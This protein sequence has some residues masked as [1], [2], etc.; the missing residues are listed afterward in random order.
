MQLSAF[1]YTDKDLE[2]LLASLYNGEIDPL[3][4]PEDLYL[5]VAKFVMGGVEKGLS[6]P[7]VEFGEVDQKLM[8]ALSENIHLFSAAKTFNFTLEASDSMFDKNGKLLPFEDFKIKATQV[9]E[10]YH[11]EIEHGTIKGGWLEAEYNTALSQAGHVKKWNQIQETKHLL[12]YLIRNEVSDATE[13]DICA[14]VN[15][16]CLPADHPFWNENA[17]D[18][19]FNC[20]GIVEQADKGEGESK[21]WD[22]DEIKQGL[23]KGDDAGRTDA[24]KFNPGKREEI[25]ATDGKSQHPYF[26][27][28][29]PYQKFAEQN[30]GLPIPQIEHPQLTKPQ[31]KELNDLP[32]SK[33]HSKAESMQQEKS[34]IRNSEKSIG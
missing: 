6:N 20:R 9:F 31:Q 11:G 16:V 5:A 26:Q 1:D 19:H 17:G 7:A 33:V 18:L 29:K 30:F 3:N 23:K 34:L 22:E 12:P 24:F 15:G 10:K 32:R 13:C 28:P 27:I 25:F 14:S 21:E 4:L 8:D 2:K